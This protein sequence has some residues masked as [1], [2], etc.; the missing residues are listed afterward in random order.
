MGNSTSSFAMGSTSI[1]VA[2]VAEAGNFF[3]D[4]VDAFF[5]DYFRTAWIESP[6]FTFKDPFLG[7]CLI[8]WF[9]EDSLNA[10]GDRSFVR[11]HFEEFECSLVTGQWMGVKHTR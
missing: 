9:P 10:I 6:R 5:S 11:D 3:Q 7:C 2:V 1:C 4:G 8:C